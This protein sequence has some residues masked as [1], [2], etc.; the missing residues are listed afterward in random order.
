M[1]DTT[2]ARTDLAEAITAVIVDLSPADLDGTVIVD[3]L[4]ASDKGSAALTAVG[5][6]LANERL[7]ESCRRLGDALTDVVEAFGL[8]RPKADT[9]EPE[10]EAH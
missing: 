6:E 1:A 10:P 3:R 2:P 7:R 8:Q 9:A 5:R 4:C